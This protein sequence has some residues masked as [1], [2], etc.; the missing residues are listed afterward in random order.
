MSTTKGNV[1]IGCRSPG[2]RP[3]WKSLVDMTRPRGNAGSVSMNNGH[4]FLVIGGYKGY[5]ECWTGG[6][7][8]LEFH[9]SSEYYDTRTGLWNE[10][11]IDMPVGLHCFGVA[12]S[13][14]GNRIFVMGGWTGSRREKADLISIDLSSGN[15]DDNCDLSTLGPRE[16]E[17]MAPMT[18]TRADFA[19]VSHENHIYVFG[20]S[21]FGIESAEKYNIETNEWQTLPTLPGTSYLRAICTAGVVGNKKIVV[22]SKSSCV[23]DISEQRWESHAPNPNRPKTASN[24]GQKNSTTERVLPRTIPELNTGRYGC[25]W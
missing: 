21:E 16:W 9:S 5:W 3:T 17:T 2:T 13:A 15:G 25:R 11:E 10:L 23:F 7:I 22:G 24:D 1:E 19:C 18:R 14:D 6:G 20:G 4:Q 8:G 12:A